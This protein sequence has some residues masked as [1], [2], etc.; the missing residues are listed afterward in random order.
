MKKIICILTLAATTSI[1][2]DFTVALDAGRLRQDV[3]TAMP[4]GSLLF[5]VAA[6]G[7]SAFS[8]SIAP[9]QYVLGNDILLSAMA[10]PASAGAFNGSGGTDE[11]INTIQINTSSLP[12]LQTGDL[13]ALRWFPQITYSS[14][15]TGTTP[16]AGQSYGT[17]NPIADGNATNDPDGGNAWAVP[18][19]G[20]T[21]NLNF[22][23]SD[24][25]LG[26]TQ[27]PSEGVRKFHRDRSPG[28]F[29]FRSRTTRDYRSRSKH[30]SRIL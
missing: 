23:T 16:S 3:A 26:G 6:G 20:S 5:L 24:S 21:I 4:A 1:Y 13:L 18:S 28:T 15:L 14:F 9:G 11:T 22:F 29:D 25:D 2:A 10:F 19:G 8:N 30:A 27:L 17:F 12:S 7:D